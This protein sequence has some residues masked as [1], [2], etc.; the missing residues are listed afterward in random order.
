VC[1]HMRT[2]SHVCSQVCVQSISGTLGV[3][4][5]GRFDTT[6]LLWGIGRMARRQG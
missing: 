5:G 6:A 3:H 1:V 2:C 4:Q